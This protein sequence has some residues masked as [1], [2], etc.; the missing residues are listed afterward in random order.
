MNTT[1]AKVQRGIGII[2]STVRREFAYA[3]FC[4]S[5][6]LGKIVGERGRAWRARHTHLLRLQIISLRVRWMLV[7]RKATRLVHT[8]TFQLISMV[9][10]AIVA[11]W[12][13][14]RLS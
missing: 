1:Q 7:R 9:L 5:R 11:F 13:G 2:W 10:L 3:S 8:H 4:A 12:A 14:E 6:L